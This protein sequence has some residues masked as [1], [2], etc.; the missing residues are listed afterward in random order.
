M[1]GVNFQHEPSIVDGLTTGPVRGRGAQLNP[2]NRFEDVRLNVLGEHLDEVM[3]ERPDGTQV[4]TVVY[5]DK[6]RTIINAVDS[7]DLPMKWTVNPYRGCEHGCVYCYARPGHEYLS[8][9]SGIDFE[10]KILAKTEAPRLLREAITRPGWAGEPLMF[11]GVTDCYQPVEAKLKITRQC[12]EVC[13][14]LAQ[15]VTI[16]TKSKLVLRDLDLLTELNRHRAVH[17]ALSVT[18]VDPEL[19]AKLEPRASSPA[20]RL[21]TVKRLAEAGIPVWVMVAPIIPGLNEAEMPAILRRA[22]DAGASGAGYVL[23]RLP[24]QVKALFVEWLYREFPDRARRVENLIRD[25]REG[26]LYN[27][28]AHTRM[29]GTGARAKQIGDMFRLFR[30]RSGLNMTWEP[31]SSEEFLRRKKERLSNGQMGLFN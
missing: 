12:L 25:T 18:S 31:C 4:K 21:K 13:A 23:L 29:V 20:E 2:G 22:A 6:S 28:A 11:S 10:T 7:P 15:P 16:V 8:L 27:A 14:E 26:D 19:S 1:Y 9:S 5:R 24:H 17:V 3:A 30:D